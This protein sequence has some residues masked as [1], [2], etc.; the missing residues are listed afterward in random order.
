MIVHVNVW[1][2]CEL[3]FHMSVVDLVFWNA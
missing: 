1:G 2:N 3:P